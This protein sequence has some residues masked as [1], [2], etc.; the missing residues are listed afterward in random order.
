MA[1][2]FISLAV[3]GLIL[4]VVA[5]LLPFTGFGGALTIPMIG[6]GLFLLV[7]GAAISGIVIL[8]D[9]LIKYWYIVLPIVAVLIF[10]YVYKEAE[11]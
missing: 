6:L 4:I 9:F 3:L 8:F 11:G 10:F 5:I 1:F 7:I 2:E